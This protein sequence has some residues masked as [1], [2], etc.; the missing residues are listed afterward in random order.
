MAPE[1]AGST[2]VSRPQLYWSVTMGNISGNGPMGGCDTRILGV[3]LATVAAVVVAVAS[4]K[5]ARNRG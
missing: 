1:V 3:L 2:P 4:L 5:G